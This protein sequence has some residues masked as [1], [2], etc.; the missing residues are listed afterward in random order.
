MNMIIYY[1]FNENALEGLTEIKTIFT[2]QY[3]AKAMIM[4]MKIGY[5]QSTYIA[6]TET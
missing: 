3:Q 5:M 1:I 4:Q 6:E 2:V